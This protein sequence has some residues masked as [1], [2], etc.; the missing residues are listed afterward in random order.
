MR[1]AARLEAARV[2]GAT[3]PR[4]ERSLLAERAEAAL[5]NLA[6][7]EATQR[8]AE[9]VADGIAAGWPTKQIMDSCGASYAEVRQARKLA[10]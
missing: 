1:E 8:R 5:V 9:A 2:Y 7:M 6:A 10:S 3:M 4:T